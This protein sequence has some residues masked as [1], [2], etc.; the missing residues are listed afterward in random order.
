MMNKRKFIFYAFLISICICI[1]FGIICHFIRINTSSMIM[2]Q[3]VD[4]LNI[5][6]YLSTAIYIMWIDNPNKKTPKE[7]DKIID[8]MNKN[9]FDEIFESFA[10]IR[11][12]ENKLIDP[13][14]NK[15]ILIV[16]SPNEYMFMSFGPNGEDDAGQGD[17]ISY[18]FDPQED[19]TSTY[20][21]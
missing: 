10:S 18:T 9:S 3:K 5:M 17:D 6:R 8:W 7:M 15:I 20:K 19:K 21:L 13:W 14:N 12:V 16:K 2:R 1:F 11:L 4:T